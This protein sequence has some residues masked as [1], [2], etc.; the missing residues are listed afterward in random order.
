[1]SA[2]RSLAVP[3]WAVLLAFGLTAN[4]GAQTLA[5]AARTANWDVVRS[6]LDRGADPSTALGDGSTALHWASYWD[7]VDVVDTLVD[8]G[9]DVDAVTDLGV[10]PLWTA[11][12]TG[13]V[14]T[15]TRL[16][17]AG[18]DASAVLP[19]GETLVMTASRSG[20]PD[21]VRL[22]VDHGADVNRRGARGQTALMWAVAQHHA[23]VVG[24]LLSYE[25]DLHARSEVRNEVVKTTPEP[26]NPE[27]VVDLQQGG[28]TPLLFAARVGDLASAKHLVRAGADVN[29]TAPYGTSATVVAAHSGHGELAAFLLEHGADANAS[30]AGYTALHAAIL[31]KDDALVEALLVHGADPNAVVRSSTPVRRD[32]IDFYIHPSYVGATPF[33]LAARFS[34]PG[35][36]RQLVEHGADP[37]VVH[38]PTYWPGS[39]SVRDDRSQVQEGDTTAVM[40]AVGMGGRSPLVA[41]ARLDR[42]A[43]M[44]PVRSTRREPDPV[45]LETLALEA[46]TIAVGHGTD[47]HI[48]NADGNTALHG[49]AAGGYDSV[50]E[51]L[52][53]R[54]ARLDLRNH[55]GQTPREW[56][57][58]QRPPQSTVELLQRLGADE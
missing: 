2:T 51:Y 40:A 58:A 28:Y 30:D 25:A 43:E 34:V 44:A 31:Y 17:H 21:V 27:Y 50:V 45:Q 47:I 24:L 26:W 54:G 4:A 9:A 48:T 19:S 36:M 46:V 3:V 1:M 52:V 56:A 39:L 8:A 37:L 38:R 57:I 49:A 18:A 6:M 32:A 33:W 22:L 55:A 53:G 12:E 16:L 14:P 20:N 35:I 15:V 41:V 13:S 7:S 23:K 11:C 29:D 5:E 10:T 42:I